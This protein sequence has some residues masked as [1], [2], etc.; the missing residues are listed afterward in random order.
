MV[1]LWNG[2]GLLLLHELRMRG[3]IAAVAAALNYSASTISHQLRQLEREVGV[4][5]LAPEGRGLRLTSAGEAVARHAQGMLA[6]QESLHGD[7]ATLAPS[8]APL[9]IAALQ[10]SARTLIPRMLDALPGYRV[11]VIVTPP[12]H[13]LFET[14]AG[15]FDLA[16]AEQYP[17]HTRPHRAGLDRELLGRDPI[18]L[19][20]GARSGVRA[21]GEAREAAWVMEP[22]GTAARAWTVQQCRAAGFEPDVR[23][24]ATDLSAHLRLIAAGHAVGLIPGLALAAEEAELR[25]IDL[26]GAPRRDVFTAARLSARA[27]PGVRAARAALADAFA[28]LPQT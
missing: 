12:E 17:G 27:L 25:L 7:L 15:A 28:A 16:M 9:R 19:A 21:L 23:Y 24:E 22:E 18:R 1:A 13:G 6:A 5:L 4:D 2:R 11:E 26:P 8:A 20:V 3:T 14:E 10:T